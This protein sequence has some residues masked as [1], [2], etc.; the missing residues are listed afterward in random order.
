MDLRMPQ[1]VTC[2]AFVFKYHFF[3]Y[4]SISNNFETWSAIGAVVAAAQNL[5]L[6]DDPT[7]WRLLPWEKRLRKRLWWQIYCMEKFTAH[8]LGRSSVI[9][10]DSYN[11]PLLSAEDHEEPGVGQHAVQMSTLAVIVSDILSRLFSPRGRNQR[12]SNF[13]GTLDT[14]RELMERTDAWYH[15]LPPQ[16]AMDTPLSPEGLNSNGFLHLTYFAVK[17]SLHKAILKV[18]PEG[19]TEIRR[20]ALQLMLDAAAWA[21][22]ECEAESRC[23]F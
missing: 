1:L 4:G 22:S 20:A 19:E 15:A 10:E 8:G 3:A 11:V 18:A 6:H 13:Q 23:L 2:F 12:A 21:R 14:A 17:I 5:G 9:P 16:L 7:D